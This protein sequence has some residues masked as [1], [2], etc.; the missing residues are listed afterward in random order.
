MGGFLHY[1]SV[2][3]V[4]FVL[5]IKVR[6]SLHDFITVV[7]PPCSHIT[8]NLPLSHWWSGGLPVWD[9]HQQCCCDVLGHVSRW[10][11]Y[12]NSVRSCEVTMLSD[13]LAILVGQE[14]S[15][16]LTQEGH[17]PKV[18]LSESTPVN[19][20]HSPIISTA[21]PC[22]SQSHKLWLFPVFYLSPPAGYLTSDFTSDD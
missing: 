11:V 14:P 5:G 3:C 4:F 12:A 21:I 7:H 1:C 8:M 15:M 19:W 13:T 6:A 10:V 20:P 9:S 2:L 22:E 16:T 17:H 18:H